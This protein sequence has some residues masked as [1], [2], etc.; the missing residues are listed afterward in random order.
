MWEVK[1][2]CGALQCRIFTSPK[3]CT[4]CLGN[5][6][7][8]EHS[9]TF[10]MVREPNRVKP[11]IQLITV[12]LSFSFMYQVWKSTDFTKTETNS[13]LMSLFC[14]T[15]RKAGVACC[16]F[17]RLV[18]SREIFVYGTSKFW[19]CVVEKWKFFLKNVGGGVVDVIYT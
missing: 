11:E 1:A 17:R 4:R 7:T 14:L 5:C 13:H 16:N 15:I 10:I 3:P 12:S 6:K 8:V 19:F 9:S 2:L 18:R